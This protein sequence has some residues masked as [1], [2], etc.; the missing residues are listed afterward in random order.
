MANRG[1]ETSRQRR[2]RKRVEKA[3]LDGRSGTQRPAAPPVLHCAAV[4]ILEIPVLLAMLATALSAC[5]CRIVAGGL[6]SPRL[7]PAR[8]NWRA[9]RAF[10]CH[11]WT[12]CCVL[13]RCPF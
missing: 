11:I 12:A 4:C 10:S 1:K 9:H 2:Y 13:M 5:R 3:K 6:Q 8:N 7:H